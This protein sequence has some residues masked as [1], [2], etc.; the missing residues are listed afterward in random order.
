MTQATIEARVPGLREVIDPTAK[1]IQVATG[2]ASVAGPVCGRVGVMHFSDAARDQ[3]W[4]YT[5]PR[6]KVGADEGEASLARENSGGVRGLTLDHQGRLLCCEATA[7]RVTREE[8]DG[9]VSVLA[10]RGGAEGLQSPDDLV[11]SVD[12]SV[13]FTDLPGLGL[14]GSGPREFSPGAVYQVTRFGNVR[15]VTAE[16]R[17][18][19]GV[20]LDARQLHLYVSDQTTREVRIFEVLADG[21][22]GP[23]HVFARFSDSSD[24]LPG[25][26]KTDEAGNVYAAGPGGLWIF[27]PDGLHLGTVTLPE[28]PTNCC[29]GRSFSGL[30]ITAGPSIYFVP[31][32]VSGTKTF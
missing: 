25:G 31:T 19:G 16:C 7:G 27:N 18:P 15:V 4:R 11:F 23:G 24:G 1:V 20:A 28:Q 17:R 26:L 3:V 9:S 21:A 5:I 13:Y 6:W 30:Y 10:N 32:R 8:V 14:P 12:G 22:L 29:W 2:F